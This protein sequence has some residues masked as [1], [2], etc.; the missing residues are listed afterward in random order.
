MRRL[1]AVGVI[2]AFASTAS[3][4][5]VWFDDFDSY[6]DQAA[7]DAVYTQIYPAV[8]LLLDQTMGYSDGQSVNPLAP[9]NNYERRAYQNF[10]A[11]MAGTDADPLIFEFMMHMNDATDW[12]TR[13]YIEIRGY[14]GEGYGDGDLLELI[15]MGCTSSGVDTTVY[16]ARVLTGLNWFNTTTPKVADWVKLTAEIKTATVDVFVNGVLNASSPRAP[17]ITFDCVVLG[18]GL[19]SNVDVH[20]DGVPEPATLSLL[21]LSGLALLR[22]R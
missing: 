4:G 15:A 19:S 22:R 14:S 10:G 6:A 21:A 17:D 5:V 8:P 18:S 13:E 20:F 11:E 1:L 2:L 16:N 7:F 9:N 12:W 3:A